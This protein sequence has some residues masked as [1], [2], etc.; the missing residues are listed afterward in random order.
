MDVL[1]SYFSKFSCSGTRPFQF[2]DVFNLENEGSDDV[3]TLIDKKVC[4]VISDGLTFNHCTGYLMWTLNNCC[5]QLQ[6]K[7]NLNFFFEFFFFLTCPLNF[8]AGQCIHYV[9]SEIKISCASSR[10][11][12]DLTYLVSVI[13]IVFLS[14]SLCYTMSS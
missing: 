5:F 12:V 3:T 8:M 7:Y 2:Q 13:F 1:V 14:L 9:Q 4:L 10:F 11:K 6:S